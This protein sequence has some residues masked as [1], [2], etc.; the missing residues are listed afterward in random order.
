MGNYRQALEDCE[1]CATIMLNSNVAYN[2]AII[3]ENSGEIDGALRIYEA[4]LGGV[5]RQSFTTDYLRSKGTNVID[6]VIRE[7]E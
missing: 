2:K 4:I 7:S 1:I 3:L 6:A 5:F